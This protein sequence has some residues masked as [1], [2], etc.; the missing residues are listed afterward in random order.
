MAN[1]TEKLEVKTIKPGNAAVFNPSFR[2]ESCEARAKKD[3]DY[4]YARLTPAGGGAD[5]VGAVTLRM[6]A[7]LTEGQSLYAFAGMVGQDPSKGFDLEGAV[8][9]VISMTLSASN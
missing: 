8:G 3:G 5:T 9:A 1:K 4:V 6:P 2:V 7:I